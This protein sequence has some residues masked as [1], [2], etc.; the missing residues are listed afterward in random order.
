MKKILILF[1]IGIL[2]V[3]CK[4]KNMDNDNDTVT[5]SPEPTSTVEDVVPT[6]DSQ[7]EPDESDIITL[8][9]NE[10]VEFYIEKLKDKDYVETYGDEEEPSVWYTAAEE[11]GMMG[12]EAIPYLIQHLKTTTD[13]YDRGLTLYAL[14]LASQD[15]GLK[16]IT[17][18]EYI[19]SGLTFSP[20]EQ[21]RFTK[22]ALEWWSKY[23]DKLLSE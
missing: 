21:D 14:L 9:P 7:E 20:E 19:Q 3:G 17:G 18:G 4:P 8:E 16:A 10:D 13:T 5:E 6:D 22:T 12:K 1:F 11:L 23:K 15:E 2:L